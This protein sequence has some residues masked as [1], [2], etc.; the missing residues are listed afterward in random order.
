MDESFKVRGPHDSATGLQWLVVRCLTGDGV[1]Q[2]LAMAVCYSEEDAM[3]IARGLSAGQL[4]LS[5]FG[6]VDSEE[7]LAKQGLP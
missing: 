7:L 3:E 2:D 1:K 4:S 6:V 5:A